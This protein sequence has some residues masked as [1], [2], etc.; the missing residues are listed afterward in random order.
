MGNKRENPFHKEGM[1]V[2]QVASSYASKLR[3]VAATGVRSC[4]L[5]VHP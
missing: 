3:K 4:L 1:T 2:H 5:P